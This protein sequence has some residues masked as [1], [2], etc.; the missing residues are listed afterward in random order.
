MIKWSVNA[1]AME[2]GFDRRTVTRRLHRV[3]PVA[4]NGNGGVYS[5]PDVFPVLFNYHGDADLEEAQTRKA[6]ADAERSELE[7]LARM[8]QVIP[9]AQIREA[10]AVIYL[11]LRQELKDGKDA[12]R[13][14]DL[15]SDKTLPPMSES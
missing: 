12:D 8:R 5:G 11:I 14:M 1:L 15:V 10:L 6:W 4:E 3:Q 9:E 7:L 13:V 2:T